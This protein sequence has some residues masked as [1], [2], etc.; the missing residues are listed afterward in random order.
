MRFIFSFILLIPLVSNATEIT[1]LYVDEGSQTLVLTGHFESSLGS[2]TIDRISVPI[3]S[4][5]DTLII[6][7][8]DSDGIGSCGPIQVHE[9]DGTM[10]DQE[11]LTWIS[12]RLTHHFVTGGSAYLYRTDEC[13]WNVV[14]RTD[15]RFGRTV[16]ASRVS[17]S[18]FSYS[19]GG[20]GDPQ[21]YGGKLYNVQ[22]S[23]SI[24]WSDPDSN[25]D[26]GFQVQAVNDG[27][28]GLV[29]S[30]SPILLH[31]AIKVITLS[32]PN[33][34]ADTLWDDY[35]FSTSQSLEILLDSLCRPIQGKLNIRSSSPQ[36]TEDYE[37][38]ADTTRYPPIGIRARVNGLGFQE[39]SLPTFAYPNPSSGQVRITYELPAGV[40]RGQII[41]LTEDGREVKRYQVT[42]AFNDLLIEESDLP[43]GSYFYKLVTDKG[44][45]QAKRIV[46]LK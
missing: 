8:I 5:S 30:F 37:W 43:N 41:L 10:S 21:N 23:G 19:G 12:L 24:N 42:N 11:I 44:E 28:K 14:F 39:L 40:Q 25:S 33:Y 36:V 32:P 13:Q 34:A 35:V 46:R 26:N 20:S 3:I 2:I 4:W 6:C 38:I 9:A 1:D 22:G 17:T 18:S 29:I 27:N 31:N 15:F 7:H 16:S 45:S